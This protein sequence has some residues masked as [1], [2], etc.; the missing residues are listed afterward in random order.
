MK[1]LNRRKF[2][3]TAGCDTCNSTSQSACTVAFRDN[4]DRAKAPKCYVIRT[5]TYRVLNSYL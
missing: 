3:Y 5:M 1:A 4:N 2:S